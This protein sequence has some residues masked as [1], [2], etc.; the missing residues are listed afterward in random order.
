MSE[1]SVV[2]PEA[3]PKQDDLDGMTGPGVAK[4]SIPEIN[5]AVEVYTGWRDKRIALSAKECE[6]K[7]KLTNLLH[8]HEGELGRAADGTIRYE[9]DETLVELTPTKEKL[10]V[11]NLHEDE[12]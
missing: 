1:F 10:R 8:A 2:E 3:K 12:D 9:Y 11:K 5:K 7:D 6:A 4:P